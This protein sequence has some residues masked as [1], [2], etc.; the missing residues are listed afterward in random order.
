VSYTWLIVGLSIGVAL[1]LLV[2]GLWLIWRLC[3]GKRSRVAPATEWKGDADLSL[4]EHVL[5]LTQEAQIERW[6]K[7]LGMQLALPVGD[8]ALTP[9]SETL[10]RT[11]AGEAGHMTRRSRWSATAPPDLPWLSDAEPATEADADFWR[12]AREAL[13]PRQDVRSL[14]SKEESERTLPVQ[15]LKQ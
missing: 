1:P 2:V 6:A 9:A 7:P 5:Q 11:L 13:E 3:K 10:L 4:Q 8:G 15:D 14:R 12:W